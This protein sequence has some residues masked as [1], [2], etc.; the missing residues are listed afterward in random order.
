VRSTPGAL[1]SYLAV[2]LVIPVIFAEAIGH[3]GK[4]V[5]EFL[6]SQAGGS[7]IQSI[8]DSPS[9]HPWPGIAVMVA[10]VVV[11]L[12]VAVVCLRRRDA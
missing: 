12:A 5:A 10:W 7:F 8:P 11:F 3:W 1:V 2:I 4:H 6:P 9:L